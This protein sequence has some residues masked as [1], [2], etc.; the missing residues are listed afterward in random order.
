MATD[1]PLRVSLT[2]PG[3]ASLGAFQAGAVSALSVMVRA[4][5]EQGRPVAIDAVGGASAG[6]IVG[7][8]AVHGMLTG[9]DVPSLL[10][11]AWVD[12]VDVDVLRSRDA[13]APLAVEQLRNDLVEFFSDV[14]DH[15][16]DVHRPLDGPVAVHVGLT[17]LL[18]FTTPVTTAGGEVSSLSFV[19]WSPFVLHPG[20]DIDTLVS[21]DGSSPLDAVLASAS[22]PI[23]FPPRRLDRRANRDLYEQRGIT[24]VDG[25]GALWYTDGGLVESQPIGR[26]LTAAK[27]IAGDQP[28]DRLHVVVDPRS[29]GPSS[30]DG[31]RGDDRHAWT[32]GLRRAM[33]IVPTQALHDDI[34]RVADLNDQLDQ[35]DEAVHALRSLCDGA[36]DDGP[37]ADAIEDLARAAGLTDKQRVDVEVISPLQRDTE[38]DVDELLAGDFAGAFGGFLDRRLRQNDY[39]LGWRSAA[40]WMPDAFERL[41][42]D[43][44]IIDAVAQRLQE[45]EPDWMGDSELTGDGIDQLDRRG[46]WR[47][48]L[49]A[50]HVGRV[51]WGAA[52]PSMPSLP[53][54][55]SVRDRVPKLGRDEQ[56]VRS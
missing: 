53:S 31:W 15:P 18:G 49:L 22:H 26:V 40:D 7:L 45:A 32:D 1:T 24:N 13:S 30:T 23:A 9:R 3:S 46:R 10:R 48:A 35:F 17:C 2:L 12:E 47:L 25:A 19:D 50:L 29:S 5:G 39:T 37:L 52:T 16:L 34:R 11:D 20:H 33:S 43:A 36:V 38:H 55:S 28:G 14:D 51:V 4:L 56:Q 42:V 54:L 8:V 6:S 21:P 41:G 27:G 44:G